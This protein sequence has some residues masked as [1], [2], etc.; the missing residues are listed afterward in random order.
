[1]A[2]S[3]RLKIALK[4]LQINLRVRCHGGTVAI[5]EEKLSADGVRL[6]KGE[7]HRGVVKRHSG[8]GRSGD[9]RLKNQREASGDEIVLPQIG[10][11]GGHVATGVDESGCG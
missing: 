1:M 5:G 2:G 6:R 3:E 4:P 8:S 7:R 10:E 9:Q 11:Y